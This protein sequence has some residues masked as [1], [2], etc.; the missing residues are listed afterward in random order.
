MSRSCPKDDFVG[1]LFGSLEDD[2]ECIAIRFGEVGQ[3]AT[4]PART[5]RGTWWGSH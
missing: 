2:G 3:D 1:K 5:P 4:G